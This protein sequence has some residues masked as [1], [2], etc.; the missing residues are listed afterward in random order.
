MEMI[1]ENLILF[2]KNFIKTSAFVFN[3]TLLFE[4]K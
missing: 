1:H 2:N 4:G 3:I